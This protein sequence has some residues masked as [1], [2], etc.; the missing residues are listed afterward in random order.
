MFV[1][2]LIQA[3]GLIHSSI[4]REDLFLNA[5]STVHLPKTT[6]EWSVEEREVFA[7]EMRKEWKDFKA[8]K[9]LAALFPI[10]TLALVAHVIA[11]L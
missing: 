11:F 4:Y 1:Q 7:S 6:Q 2:M 10:A 8:I 9:V 3:L 5:L